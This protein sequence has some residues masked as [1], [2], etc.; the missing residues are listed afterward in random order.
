MALYS[1][2]S[3]QKTPQNRIFLFFV[4]NSYAKLTIN[5]NLQSYKC[6][7]LIYNTPESFSEV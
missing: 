1:T 4:L 3:T 2:V 6:N 7:L 5:A